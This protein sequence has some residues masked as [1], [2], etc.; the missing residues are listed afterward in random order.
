ME[1]RRK[2]N[3]GKA[4]VSEGRSL[5][6]WKK[7]KEARGRQKISWKTKAPLKSAVVKIIRLS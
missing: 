7:S 3:F 2:S 1:I 6:K 4:I 5:K